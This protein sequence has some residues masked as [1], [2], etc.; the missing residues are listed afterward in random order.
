[1]WCRRGH[2][3]AMHMHTCM[4]MY[5]CVWPLHHARQ[6]DS[7]RHTRHFVMGV[8]HILE[9]DMWCTKQ[10]NIHSAPATAYWALKISFPEAFFWQWITARGL[11]AC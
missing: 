7:K 9:K 10:P 11:G 4:R 1:M 3:L 6:L 2:Q 8:M 5:A